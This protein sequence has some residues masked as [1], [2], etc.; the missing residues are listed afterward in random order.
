MDFSSYS[1]HLL[2]NVAGHDIANLLGFD[3]FDLVYDQF[4]FIKI[5]GKLL[6]MLADE[7][8][9]KIFDGNTL[10]ATHR[11]ILFDKL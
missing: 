7:F 11:G 4:I 6:L 5:S 8:V 1:F 9:A 3:F 10:N 2:G